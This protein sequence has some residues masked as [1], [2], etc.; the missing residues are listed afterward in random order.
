MGPRLVGLPTI[1]G[2]AV[3]IDCAAGKDCKVEAKARTAAC[4]R[5][6]GYSYTT[7]VP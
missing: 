1:L 4:T 7:G 3:H 6:Y 2:T 5:C